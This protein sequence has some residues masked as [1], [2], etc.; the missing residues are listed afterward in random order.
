MASTRRG[1]R[2][3]RRRGGQARRLPTLAVPKNI[4]SK[5]VRF[6]H[7]WSDLLDD[8]TDQLLAQLP[9]LLRVGAMEVGKERTDSAVEAWDVDPYFDPETGWPFY[10]EFIAEFAQHPE[11]PEMGDAVV[12]C[13][14]RADQSTRSI[15][16]VREAVDGLG[17][18]YTR[19]FDVGLADIDQF[20]LE[21]DDEAVASNLR[22]H[23]AHIGASAKANPSLSQSAALFAVDE[24]PGISL[25]RRK[26]FVAKQLNLIKNKGGTRV[27]SIPARHF[28]VLRREVDRGIF[29]GLRIE[30]IRDNIEQLK[31]VT[32]R[33]ATTIA[34]DQIGKY[35][36]DMMQ[37][38]QKQLGIDGYIWTTVGDERVR[39][40]HEE[41]DGDPFL[42]SD[43]PPDG[44][45][46]EPINCRCSAVPNLEAGLAKLEAA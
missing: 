24:S 5:L 12:T 11:I 21:F 35:H 36:G 32:R 23:R 40:S 27:P 22:R 31:G 43:P 2:G 26:Q 9:D 19:A 33:R 29:E 25:G 7:Q 1:N 45:P 13:G 30:S 14:V 20:L 18:Q 41:R 3:G 37:V 17:V 38:R 15:A 39:D 10:C 46:S 16:V 4:E 42:W 8:L 34:R 44:H 6:N 28:R